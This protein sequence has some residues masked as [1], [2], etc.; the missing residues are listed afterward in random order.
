[1]ES[2]TSHLGYAREWERRRELQQ[3]VLLPLTEV[4]GLLAAKPMTVEP[5][6]ITTVVASP[7]LRNDFEVRTG[8]GKGNHAV[9]RRVT[10]TSRAER[11]KATTQKELRILA[12]EWG[13][14]SSGVFASAW[15]LKAPPVS[16]EAEIDI[17]PTL[18]L[19]CQAIIQ[20][21]G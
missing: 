21:V 12:T 14:I 2:Q 17:N 9:L 1:M 19:E 3:A 10:M 20:G 7:A 18:V 11:L 6:G 15:N 16:I 5:D 8:R 13:R 4:L